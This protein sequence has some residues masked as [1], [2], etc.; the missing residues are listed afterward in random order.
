MCDIGE[1]LKRVYE[2]ILFFIFILFFRMKV[3]NVYKDKIDQLRDDEF[4]GVYLSS[5]NLINYNN[6]QHF[7]QPKILRMKEHMQLFPL[8]ILLPKHS[9]LKS[10]FDHQILAFQ[11][12][13]L[14]QHWLKSF[15]KTIKD[16]EDKEPRKL[17][18][19]QIIGIIEICAALHALSFLIFIMELLTW[20]YK[21][22]KYIIDFFTFK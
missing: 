6:L 4:R 22:I 8:I 12:S 13:G 21:K 18:I 16:I 17:K 9:C 2:R 3:F 20:K 10:S 7:R 14:I 11:S 15:T 1:Y 19:D 5:I